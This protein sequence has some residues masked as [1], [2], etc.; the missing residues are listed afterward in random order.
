VNRYKVTI[1]RVKT[2][3]RK[4]AKTTWPL[5]A[6]SLAVQSADAVIDVMII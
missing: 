4:K 2:K 6:V 3:E 5:P 1:I